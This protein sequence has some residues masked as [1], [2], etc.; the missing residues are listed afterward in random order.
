MMSMTMKTTIA[1]T[2]RIKETVLYFIVTVTCM[3]SCMYIMAI[4]FL[5][6]DS[7]DRAAWS[8]IAGDYEVHY[9]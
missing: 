2:R 8:Q 3:L 1:T 4:T 5:V 9:G 6:A 7:Q